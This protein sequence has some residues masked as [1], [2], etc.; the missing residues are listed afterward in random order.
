MVFTSPFF[1]RLFDYPNPGYV[2]SVSSGVTTSFGEIDSDSICRAGV[3]GGIGSTVGSLSDCSSTHPC[4]SSSQREQFI[5]LI[6]KN[7]Y[8]DE[9][10]YKDND[11]NKK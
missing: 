11:K 9:Q 4:R 1:L 10:R 3:I 7:Y 8:H 6:E 5:R 2:V